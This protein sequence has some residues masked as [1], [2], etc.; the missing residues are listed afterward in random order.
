MG[1]ALYIHELCL[2][3]GD[4]KFWEQA[5]G[6]L[7]APRLRE[8]PMEL[9]RCCGYNHIQV[10]HR[11]PCLRNFLESE[12]SAET[13]WKAELSG[14]VGRWEKSSGVH[15]PCELMYQDEQIRA[16]QGVAGVPEAGRCVG[17]WLCTSCLGLVI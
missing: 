15:H 5:H 17:V 3:V 14:A 13:V 10:Q 8:F 16:R 2:A 12:A 11:E 6:D 7:L 4:Q 9:S 1:L